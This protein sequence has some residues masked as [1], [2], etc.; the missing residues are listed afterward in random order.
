MLFTT[1]GLEFAVSGGNDADGRRFAAAICSQVRSEAEWP[2][3]EELAPIGGEKRLALWSNTQLALPQPPEALKKVRRLRLQLVTPAAFD[4]G[5]KPGWLA[6][7]NGGSPPGFPNV[8]LRLVGA[9]VPRPIFH[10]G[11]DLTRRAKDAQKATRLLAP[12]GSVYFFETDA[13]L[14]ARSLWMRSIC[15]GEQD[16]RDGFGIVLC[17]GWEWQ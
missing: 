8:R 11:W 9:A 12:A 5:W 15:D 10:S 14:D 4:L 3:I 13:D 7:Q 6:E 1:E 2:G 17:G 16:R